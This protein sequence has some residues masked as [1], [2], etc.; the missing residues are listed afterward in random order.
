MFIE[1]NLS[2]W[3]LRAILMVEKLC[4]LKSLEKSILILILK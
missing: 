4:K 2:L 3:T 1:G